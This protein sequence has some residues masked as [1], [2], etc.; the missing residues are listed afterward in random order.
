MNA[1][2]APLS[3]TRGYLGGGNVAGILGVSP[4]KSP[5]D[6][7]LTI[8]SEQ[9]EEISPAQRRFFER[10][11]ALEPFAAACFEEATGLRI[12]KRNERY[13]DAH[14]P[15]MRAE[16][17]F[18]TEDGASGECKTVHP[19]AVR[20]WG[21]P[22]LDEEPPMYV[23]AQ[24][25]W[26]L[27]VTGRSHAYVHALV[28]LDDDRIYR[29]ERDET[30]IANI[31]AHAARFW[32]YHIE[33]RR[34]PQ[35]VNADD[36]LR[37]Y[38]RDSGRAVEADAEIRA[39][40]ETLTRARSQRQLLEAEHDAAAFRIKAF[41]RDATTLLVAG[42]PALTWKARADGVRVFRLK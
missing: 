39:A 16:L 40:L 15:W 3:P 1:Q 17:D 32:K 18:E 13:T 11:K 38:A 5:L 34:P 42:Q 14:Y 6:E 20:D 10:R 2:L 9:A 35:P 4:F 21:D 24:V 27:G 28:G 23:T 29:I 22:D 8:T 31:R 33:P 36:V 25:M 30:L 26:G 37:L 41:M 19:N 7:Y 12:I